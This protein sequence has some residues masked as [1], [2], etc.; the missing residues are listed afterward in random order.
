MA[1]ENEVV[2]FV[3]EIELDPQDKATFTKALQDAND[4]CDALRQSISDT[5][6]QMAKM[7]A[8]GKENSDEFKKLEKSLQA[9]KDQLKESVKAANKYSSALDINNKSIKELRQYS[10]QLRS[11]LNA[12]HKE[13]NPQLWK[14]YNNELKRVED[15]LKD[16][17]IGSAGIKEPMLSMRKIF[18][19]MKT[20]PGIIGLITGAIALA[21]KSLIEMAEASQTWGDRID[22][23]QAQ[24]S[25]AWQHIVAQISNGNKV[26]LDSIRDVMAAAKEA[27]QLRDGLFEKQN[28][29]KI[30]EAKAQ[31]YIAEQE[32]IV[33]DS[34]KSAE[35][36]LKAQQNILDKEAELAGYRKNIATDSLNAALLDLKRTGLNSAEVEKLVD[37]Y[38]KNENLFNDA[39]ASMVEYNEKK[40][41]LE[42]QLAEA[43]KTGD[44]NLKAELNM[45]LKELWK[46]YEEAYYIDNLIK[47]YDLGN[48]A[49][50]KAYVDAKVQM[51]Q[52][53]AQVE[54]AKATRMR[55]TSSF[56]KQIEDEEKARQEQAFN[57]KIKEADDTYTKELTALKNSLAD[58]KITEEEYQQKSLAA[59]GVYLLKKKAILQAYGKDVIDIENQIADWRLDAGAPRQS[60]DRPTTDLSVSGS[61][62]SKLPGKATSEDPGIA[63]TFDMEMTSLNLL[64]EAKVI[65]EEEFLK[66]RNELYEKYGIE[67]KEVEQTLW[68]Q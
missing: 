18:E 48:D 53:D 38:L 40:E 68:E 57:D 66:R 21:K 52:A 65:S 61:I 67:Q 39:K 9:N 16:L 64:H 55:K 49:L 63:K 14:K 26:S 32:Q 5:A 54:Q 58:K 10:N 28:S 2:R 13:A 34:T 7:R 20:V 15:R 59:E 50:V 35:E 30:E 23:W 33:N 27:Q 43:I 42:N 25:Q 44:Y 24:F 1:I 60:P 45:Q 3:A 19:N 6:N 12:M 17:K 41:K 11:A 4:S 46:E 51:E 36:R 22:L 8:E 56:V 29:L 37:G 31:K 47:K 62:V